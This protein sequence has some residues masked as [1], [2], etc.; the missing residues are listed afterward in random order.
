MRPIFHL[1]PAIRFIKVTGAD[2]ETFLN[3]QLSQ[4]IDLKGPDR[5]T[6]AA[7]HDSKG[8]VLALLHV[9]T[10]DDGWL[11]MVHGENSEKITQ[12]LNLFVLRDNV[13]ICD[14]SSK[15]FGA[16]LLNNLNLR[17]EDHNKALDHKYKNIVRKD[18]SLMFK[19]NSQATYLVALKDRQNPTESEF[20]TTTDLEGEL[21]EIQTGLVNIPPALSQRFTP[22]MLNLDKLGAL[23]FKKG[24][25]PGQEVIA[26]IQNLGT[27]KR[28]VFRYSGFLSCPPSIGSVLVDL[29][30]T[31]MGEVIRSVQ[32][33]SQRVELLAIIRIDA[34][35]KPLKL[36]EEPQ[37]PLTWEPLPWDNL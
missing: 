7:W 22:Q 4:N 33:N 26:R 10:Y 15:W 13:E 37:K 2:A 36:S 34:V 27:V 35:K 23:S 14:V 21:A 31:P 5:A 9:F 3:A 30:G 16:I 6:L 24:C 32:T 29:E 25:Y 18:D 1:L 28:R 20:K 17:I 12:K 11:L 19:L 8:R